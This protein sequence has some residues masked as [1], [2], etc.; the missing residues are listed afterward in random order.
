MHY[1][2]MRLDDNHWYPA[3]DG[4]FSILAALEHEGMSKNVH[5][6]RKFY[7]S[8]VYREDYDTNTGV[9]NNLLTQNG[10]VPGENPVGE[11]F[12]IHL[13]AIIGSISVIQ[14]IFL[15]CY[16]IRLH[17]KNASKG[18]ADLEKGD[19]DKLFK[20]VMEIQYN[21]KEKDKATQVGHVYGSASYVVPSK[22]D[23]VDLQKYGKRFASFTVF[24]PID[25]DTESSQT[26]ESDSE[27]TTLFFCE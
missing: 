3:F 18:T 26:S 17:R 11:F 6:L 24:R 8:R 23:N 5:F 13:C 25:V 19:G 10:T 4:V 16:Y 2:V 9:S 27:Q 14:L 20:G 7:K 22:R 21:H 15:I 12:K 1:V